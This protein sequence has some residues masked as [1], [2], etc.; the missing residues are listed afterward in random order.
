VTDK[1]PPDSKRAEPPNPEIERLRDEIRVS[2][3][4]ARAELVRIETLLIAARLYE[5][6]K[7]PPNDATRPP[8]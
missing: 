6:K 3:D 8:T 7:S 5:R 4:R 1:T 2:L